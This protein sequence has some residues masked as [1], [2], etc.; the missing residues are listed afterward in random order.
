MIPNMRVL[1]LQHYGETPE[2]DLQVTLSPATIKMVASKDVQI[3]GRLVKEVT[4]LFIDSDP[5]EL[6]LSPIDL[7]SLQSV[8]GAYGFYDEQ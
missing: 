2:D 1:T 8:V 3:Q 5:V 7:L 4:I 6:N